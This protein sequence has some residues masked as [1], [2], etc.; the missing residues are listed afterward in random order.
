MTTDVTTRFATPSDADAIAALHAD[1]IDEGFLVVLGRPFLERLYR[2]VTGGD[3][4]FVVVSD[5][6]A[7]MVNGFVAVAEN[8]R[9]LYRDFLRHDGL[10]AGWV[11]APA[12]LRHPWK[13]F[14]TLRYGV[15]GDSTVPGAEI[16]ST[17]VA[18]ERRGK[19][20]GRALVEAAMTEL[21][22][23]GIEHAHVV[24][25]AG[26]DAAHQTYMHCGFR[27]HATVEV[28]RGIAQD[29]LVWP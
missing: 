13:V 2:R 17:A 6:S 9:Q 16:L 14:E 8:T 23:R 20:I 29:V 22:R 11:G 24:T 15:G 21:R 12:I 26:N 4:S 3:G 19:G 28:H 27:H 18:S 7:G 10:R 1:S 5:E 25:A